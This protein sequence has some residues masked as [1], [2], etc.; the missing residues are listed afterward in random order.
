MN[1][2]KVLM[3]M[4]AALADGG[5]GCDALQQLQNRIEAFQRRK[6]PKQPADAKLAHC[7][8]EI[9]ELRADPNDISE[10]AD[11]LILFLGAA[12][13][14]CISSEDL[15][16]A[17]HAKMDVNECRKWGEPDGEGVCRHID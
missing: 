12:A 3:P 8:R 7:H 15:I 1:L 14:Q 9:T 13:C 2:L 17:A 6:F 10:W 16:R 11:V 4:H 5:G